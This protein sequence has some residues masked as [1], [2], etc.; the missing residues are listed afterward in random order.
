[1]AHATSLGVF[2][3]S[4]PMLRSAIIR[5]DGSNDADVERHKVSSNDPKDAPK[6]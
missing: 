3:R 5:I 1:M 2:E 4:D 6:R